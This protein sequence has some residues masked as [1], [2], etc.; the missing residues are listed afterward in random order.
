MRPNRNRP[1]IR[2]AAALAQ[3][4]NQLFTRI[5]LSA[6]WLVTV[7]VAHQT[8]SERDVVQEIAMNM[9]AINLASPPIANLD[10]AVTGRTA[11]PDHKM[12][13]KAVLHFA[14]ASMVVFEHAR[15]S[16]PR[17]AV[18][19]DDEFPAVAGNGRAPNLFDNRSAEIGVSLLRSRS[20]K[21]P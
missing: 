20:R 2:F 17:S 10:F 9:A 13:G 3:I 14:N 18:M 4:T 12:V 21:R 16:L 5:E 6:S 1:S 7:E 19:D 15:I 8:N 11:V